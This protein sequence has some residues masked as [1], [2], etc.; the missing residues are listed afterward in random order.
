MV[1]I[2]RPKTILREA[3]FEGDIEDIE[4]NL[5]KYGGFVKIGEDSAF[6]YRSFNRED[7]SLI[8]VFHAPAIK[9]LVG[10][11]IVS[12]ENQKNQEIL[13]ELEETLKLSIV[14]LGPTSKEYESNK[15]TQWKLG[16][17]RE[18]MAE[19]YREMFLRLVLS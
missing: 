1:T 13:S 17:S 19:I 12:Y 2:T 8:S 4:E 7:P 14:P 18:K 11:T 15:E 6:D 5:R 3:R 9:N 10:I 16:D